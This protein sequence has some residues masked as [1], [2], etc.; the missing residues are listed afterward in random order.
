MRIEQYELYDFLMDDSFRAGVENPDGPESIE[1]NL[2]LE[3]YPGKKI[4]AQEAA[5]I[6]QSSQYQDLQFSEKETT[7]LWRE[8]RRDTYEAKQKK[9]ESPVETSTIRWRWL[10]RAAIVFIP[11][12]ALILM[13]RFSEEASQAAEETSIVQVEKQTQDGQ[14]L[15]ITFSDGTQ[16][17]LNADTKLTYTDPFAP[18]QREVFLEGEAFFDVTPDPDRPFIVH[19]GNLST[20]VLGTS[21]NIRTYPEEDAIQV[22]VVTGKVMVANNHTDSSL[23][24]DHTVVL[25]PSEMATYDKRSLITRVASVNIDR[26]T[27]WNQDILVFDNARFDE[28]VEQLE[29][30]YGVEFEILRQEPIKKGFDGS[31]QHKSLEHVLEGISYTSDFEYE[32]HGD[33]V[34]IR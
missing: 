29:R 30:W 10:L 34:F 21:F 1:W 14:K 25:Q 22:A 18:E 8:I 24:D 28:V 31:F 11:L 20:K 3:A 6:I 17:K 5:L 7:A 16:V 23:D 27:A 13:L 19:T 4:L 12:F 26:I 9:V 2:I 32:I 33:T 15:Q